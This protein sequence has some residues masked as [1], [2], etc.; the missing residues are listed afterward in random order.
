[1]TYVTISWKPEAFELPYSPLFNRSRFQIFPVTNSS[2]SA[3]F[4]TEYLHLP[5]NRRWFL[6]IEGKSAACKSGSTWD[7][8]GAKVEFWLKVQSQKQ[9]VICVQMQMGNLPSLWSTQNEG[10]MRTNRHKPRGKLSLSLNLL[11]R[12]VFKY[13]L[14]YLLKLVHKSVTTDYLL[15]QDD[16]QLFKFS[17][18]LWL[19]LKTL[20]PFQKTPTAGLNSWQ[21]CTTVSL[22]KPQKDNDSL[23]FPP[24]WQPN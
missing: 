14:C 18:T 21:P 2:L 20:N 11:N 17:I 23:T 24:A 8:K 7:W 5:L 15:R 1:M 6:P 9:H 16:F 22:K 12:E 3:I 10:K 19:Y 4:C 13:W